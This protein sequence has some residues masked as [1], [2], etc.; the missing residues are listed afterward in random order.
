[1]ENFNCIRK[2]LPTVVDRLF[3]SHEYKK[4]LSVPF[5]LAI[6]ASWAK[7][8]AEEHFKED[9]LELMSMME[10]FNAYADKKMYVE[11]EK[12]FEKRYPFVEKISRGFRHTVYDLFKVYPDSPPLEQA[13]PSKPSSGQAP[14]EHCNQSAY[15]VILEGDC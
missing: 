15:D 7:G 4:S 5:N 10:N 8:L 6:Q 14:S 2:L 11:Y 13:P 9:L 12:L 1:M 3:Q